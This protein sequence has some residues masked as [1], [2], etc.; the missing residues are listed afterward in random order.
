METMNR[1]SV[2]KILLRR[3]RLVNNLMTTGRLIYN[4]TSFKDQGRT[5]SQKEKVNTARNVA[6]QCVRVH[7]H[8]TYYHGVLR[9]AKV[10]TQSG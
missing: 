5:V 2:R 8:W 7:P 3:P 9:P 4:S 6:A 10:Q 1:L